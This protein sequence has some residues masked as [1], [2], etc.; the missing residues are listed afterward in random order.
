MASAH[1]ID[2]AWCIVGDVKILHHTTI[3]M[4]VA[5]QYDQ[6]SVFGS[7]GAYAVWTGTEP[8]SYSVNASMVG[9]NSAEIRFNVAQAEAAYKWT[10]QSPPQC[11]KLQL[12]QITTSLFS[13]KVRIESTESSIQEMVHIQSGH[14]I[15]I[16]LSMSLKECKA[17]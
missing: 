4:S 2:A 17:I 11:K 7:H 9:A 1:H 5:V 8:R 15:Q 16:D 6:R 3:S 14:P 13:T 10:Q 12:P